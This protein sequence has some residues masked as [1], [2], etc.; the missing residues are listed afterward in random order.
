M[1]FVKQTNLIKWFCHKNQET[2]ITVPD[3]HLVKIVIKGF[4]KLLATHPY[5][6]KSYCYAPTHKKSLIATHPTNEKA[7]LSCTHT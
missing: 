1:K 7:L 2:L 5:K 6:H 4:F 3:V